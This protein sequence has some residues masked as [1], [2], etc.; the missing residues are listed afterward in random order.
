M[1]VNLGALP[2]GAGPKEQIGG[3]V[4]PFNDGLYFSSNKVP[5]SLAHHFQLRRGEFLKAGLFHLFGNL[6]G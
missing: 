6:V 3:G 1:T 5:V 4:K 2:F